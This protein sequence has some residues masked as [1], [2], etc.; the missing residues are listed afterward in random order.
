MFTRAAIEN[1]EK[2]TAAL[3]CH[4]PRRTRGQRRATSKRERGLEVRESTQ[5]SVLKHKY[6]ASILEASLMR[7]QLPAWK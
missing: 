4:A 3:C 6:N 2:Q 5:C 1:G 7:D